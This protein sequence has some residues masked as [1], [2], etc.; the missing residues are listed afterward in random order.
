[1][2]DAHRWSQRLGH[3]HRVDG[4]PG[5]VLR[6]GIRGRAHN[7]R[8]YPHR[9]RHRACMVADERAHKE[10]A[11]G[12]RHL[13]HRRRATSRMKEARALRKGPSVGRS[14]PGA[15]A[16]ADGG[17]AGKRL[18]PGSEGLTPTPSAS[19]HDRATNAALN[20]GRRGRSLCSVDLAASI[21]LLPTNCSHSG[22]PTPSSNGSE[23]LTFH[24]TRGCLQNDPLPARARGPP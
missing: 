4:A 13:R 1:M 24:A 3:E 10:A 5:L 14:G 2:E 12:I 7:D 16:P 18:R 6:A 9:Q 19:M 22:A 21:F 8:R 17:H 23:R 20:R 15:K 11:R